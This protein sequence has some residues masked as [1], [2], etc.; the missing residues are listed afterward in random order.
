MTL[1]GYL[2]NIQAQTGKTPADFRALAHQKGLTKPSEI[3]AWLKADFGLG[4]G[5]A[6]AIVHVLSLQAGPKVSAADQVGAH[7][8]GKR[9]A[10][11]PPYEALM[12]KVSRFG[13]DVRVAPTKSYLSLLRGDKKFGVLAPA[14]PERFD[15]GL[16]LKGVPAAGR[17]EASGSWNNMVTHRVRIGAPKEI[18]AEVLAWLKQAYQAAQ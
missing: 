9:A 7:F 3:I 6:R 15:I 13:G 1:K 10:W 18:D 14:T 17:L 11:R 8:T 2:D 16:K 5:H 4:T 12:K